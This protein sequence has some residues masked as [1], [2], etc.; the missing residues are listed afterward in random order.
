MAR[1][2]LVE[3]YE[4]IFGQEEAAAQ[5][6]FVPN[7]ASAVERRAWAKLHGFIWT[8]HNI[9]AAR[10]KR[11][12]EEA[13]ACDCHYV[14]PQNPGMLYECAKGARCLNR[15][16]QILAEDPQSGVDLEIFDTGGAKG[17]GVRPRRDLYE[18]ELIIEYVGRVLHK[19]PTCHCCHYLMRADDVFVDA[20]KYGNTAR[21]INHSCSPSAK[22]EVW[23]IPTLDGLS[24][25]TAVG[26]FALLAV[27]A[28]EELTYDYKFQCFD[29]AVPTPCLCGASLCRGKL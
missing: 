1:S 7:E 4:K 15:R 2:E 10:K 21:F 12:S 29:D 28:G 6:S 24:L 11:A 23:K 17:W 20:A 14:Q 16:L 13:F 22:V 9:L 5:G 26:I 18:G 27:Q 25:R 3:F 19:V 8:D